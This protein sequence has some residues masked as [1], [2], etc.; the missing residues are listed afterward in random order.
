MK[1]IKEGSFSIR[2]HREGTVQ[3]T[4]K[5]DHWPQTHTDQASHKA[6]DFAIATP[7]KTTRQG[8]TDVGRLMTGRLVQP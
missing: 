2:I 5:N 8:D 3:Q 6:Y 4:A 7:H 1:P